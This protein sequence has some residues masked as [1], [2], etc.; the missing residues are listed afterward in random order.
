M[1]FNPHSLLTPLVINQE[2]PG[3]LFS[4][5]LIQFQNLFP[6]VGYAF[7]AMSLIL[8]GLPLLALTALG[9]SILVSA[10]KEMTQISVR[11]RTATQ[12]SMRAFFYTKYLLVPN[13]TESMPQILTTFV[14][15]RGGKPR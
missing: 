3:S 2:V 9:G 4:N 12:S 1:V 10:K 6:P 14:G 11:W 15:S 13:S 8:S 5:S 7:N